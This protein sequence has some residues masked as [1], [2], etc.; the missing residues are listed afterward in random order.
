LQGNGFQGI[1]SQNKPVVMTIWASEV[2]VRQENDSANL[3]RPI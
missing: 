3:S 2:A 1:G